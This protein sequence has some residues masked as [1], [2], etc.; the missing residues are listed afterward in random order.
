MARKDYEAFASELIE[1]VGG[2]DN[3]ISATN[4]MTRMRFVLK[5]ESIVDDSKVKA[6]DGVMSVVHSGG[7]YQIPIG[8]YVNEIAAF[9][10]KQ[11]GENKMTE[12]VNEK[13]NDD[14]IAENK[15]KA[16]KM[17][18]VKKDS[19]YN[20]FFRA[21]SGCILPSIGIMGASGIIK[22]ILTI[23]TSFGLMD[24]AGGTYQILWGIADSVMYFMPVIFGFS[25]GKQFGMNQ[26]TAAILG[27]GL[28]YP[29]LMSYVGA[30]AP[31]TFLGITVGMRNYSSTMLPII[32]IV[33]LASYVEKFAK[34]YIPQ[35]L[36]LMFV[37]A[38]VLVIMFPI[39]LIVIGPFMS[40]LQD[41]LAT[42]V[43][44]LFN[45]VP[46][47]AS[48]ILGAFWQVFVL[49]GIHA[50]MVPIILNNIA[51]LGY[52]PINGIL[53]IPVFAL[54]GMALGFAIKTKNKEAKATSL[55]TMGSALC[56]ITEPSIYLVAMTDV[57]RFVCAFIGGGI[58]GILGG[59]MRIKY[60][61]YTG[62]GLFEIPGMINPA[63]VDISFYGFII[64]SLIAFIISAVCCYIIT[65]PEE[66]LQN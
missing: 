50:G 6:I 61:T 9:V 12:T 63:G 58:S 66:G 55:G 48:G 47:L 60:Y 42:A 19:F 22:G 65:K 31:L 2:P 11:I 49:L 36:Q 39:S 53:G 41:G 18:V 25:A 3:I 4:C 59:I 1:A 57:K 30:E 43:N 7:Q 64:C 17:R 26:Y 24:A 33:F 8:T 29:T 40:M 62:A 32:L 20:R 56:G 14:I 44:G 54:A 13:N 35:M 27:A 37:P 28:I 34:K 23:L 46:I 21:I 16:E 45:A 5:D 15:E 38:V 10:E 52:C 51:T